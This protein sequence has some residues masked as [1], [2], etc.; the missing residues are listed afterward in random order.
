MSLY[1]RYLDYLNQTMP[2]ISGIFANTPAQTVEEAMEETTA[3]PAGLTPEQLALL[4]PQQNQ[5]GRDDG[6][7]GGGKFGN[8]DLTRSK[9]FIKDVYDEELGD[10]IPTKLTAYYNP[11]LGNFQTFDGKNIN[12]AFTN[13]PLGIFGAG[14]DFLGLRPDTVGGY[15][16]GKIRGT[17][18]TPMD[19]IK[20]DRNDP[21]GRTPQQ[22]MGI[23]SLSKTYQDIGRSRDAPAT[24]TGGNNSGMSS[25]GSGGSTAANRARTSSRVSGGRTRAYGL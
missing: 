25:I 21:P 20:G 22:E 9:T 4:Y 5:G 23:Q 19:M 15:A 18:D 11:T 16:P 14:L 3:Q 12:P 2:N 1:Q 7:R 10:F 24:S 13:V 17:Y 8:L 6:F